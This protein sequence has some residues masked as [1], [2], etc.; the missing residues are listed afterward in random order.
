MIDQ[1]LFFAKIS[2]VLLA[3]TVFWNYSIYHFRTYPDYIQNHKISDICLD[4]LYGKQSK[5]RTWLGIYGFCVL[6]L[7]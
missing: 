2:G 6:Y 1:S 3:E 5:K 7:S 4:A